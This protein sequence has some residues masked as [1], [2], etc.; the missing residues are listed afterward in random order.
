MSQEQNV[1]ILKNQSDLIDFNTQ[2]SE[3]VMTGDTQNSFRNHLYELVKKDKTNEY[4]LGKNKESQF[5]SNKSSDVY[6]DVNSTQRLD[7][8]SKEQDLQMEYN[9][10][11]L[12]IVFLF[13]LL[14]I[15]PFL[16]L[17]FKLIDSN[18]TTLLLA[19]IAVII[20][21][22]ILRRIFI[23]RHTYHFNKTVWPS[24]NQLGVSNV[25]VDEPPKLST[26]SLR[27]NRDI[28]EQQEHISVPINRYLLLLKEHMKQALDSQ[29][30]HTASYLQEYIYDIEVKMSS[31]NPEII[32]QIRNLDKTK[33]QKPQDDN[34][35]ELAQYRQSM[36]QYRAERNELVK[37]LEASTKCGGI[38]N[39]ND[40]NGDCE[41][42]IEH[43]VNTYDFNKPIQVRIN[44]L[45]GYQ[46][47][48][49]EQ[50]KRL[51]TKIQDI[52]D[53]MGEESDDEEIEKLQTQIQSTKDIISKLNNGWVIKDIDTDILEKT[54]DLNQ[55]V[56]SDAPFGNVNDPQNLTTLQ[57]YERDDVRVPK[58][59]S[60]ALRELELS[61]KDK[62]EDNQA[63]LNN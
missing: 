53:G 14:S 50:I 44:Q 51:T 34:K 52:K 35:E 25:N 33:P 46:Q 45:K 21:L 54:A 16:L 22:Y 27:Q 30:Y 38:V 63:K 2:I 40:P 62:R 43:L 37:E 17:K 39:P 42:Y 48:L 31:G 58:A 10:T 60:I 49:E 13:L 24:P 7:I 57:F 20:F 5:T 9:I 23:N 11:T 15:V 26:D 12:K 18:T 41:A 1:D 36:R 28:A 19:I 47:V 59:A 3:A 61:Q 6:N 55:P 4:I 56:P 29:D 32:D 8:L